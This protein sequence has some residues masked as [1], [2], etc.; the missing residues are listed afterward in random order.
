M[1]VTLSFVLSLHLKVDF[2]FSTLPYNELTYLLRD[3]LCFSYLG[4]KL[5]PHRID[6]SHHI[7]GHL[8]GLT[9]FFSSNSS[10]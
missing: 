8:S 3:L 9:S 7:A 5:R 1:Q 6:V 4:V 2:S 10:T